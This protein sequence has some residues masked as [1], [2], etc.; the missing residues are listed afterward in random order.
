MGRGKSPGEGW[1]EGGIGALH[2]A[3]AIRGL[4][5]RYILPRP[6][7]SGASTPEKG[8]R[9]SPEELFSWPPGSESPRSEGSRSS[10]ESTPKTQ[11]TFRKLSAEELLLDSPNTKELMALR[12]S[13]SLPTR[14]WTEDELLRSL[15][16]I[17]TQSP[18]K[19][20]NIFSTENFRPEPIQNGASEKEENFLNIQKQEVN[21]R[22]VR[23]PLPNENVK[24]SVSE[25]LQRRL[26]GYVTREDDLPM[27]VPF[28]HQTN[29]KCKCC[30]VS[31]SLEDLDPWTPWAF[32]QSNNSQR[33]KSRLRKGSFRVLIIFTFSLLLL[34]I[35]LLYLS[36]A[37]KAMQH[38]LPDY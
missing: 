27:D 12:Q 2:F 35:G 30:K 19:T 7:L 28:L 37:T 31:K 13:P 26:H 20:E 24:L 17:E 38:G 32:T 6:S 18:K 25:E 33:K 29:P 36:Q 3:P 16:T 5:P 11:R 21:N 22:H 14:T 9:K 15:E 4:G 34:G 8:K 1:G 10:Q 23:D